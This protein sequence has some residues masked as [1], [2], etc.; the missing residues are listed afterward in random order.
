MALNLKTCNIRYI[1][2]LDIS[3]IWR[4]TGREAITYPMARRLV[5]SMMSCS[6]SSDRKNLRPL[7]HRHRQMT[8]QS[9]VRFPMDTRMWPSANR[10]IEFWTRNRGKKNIVKLICSDSAPI[11]KKT[12][13]WINHELI[14][15]KV[16][17]RAWNSWFSLP[18]IPSI[19]WK[20]PTKKNPLCDYAD[21]MEAICS[22]L[23][24]I[25]IINSELIYRSF[26]KQNAFLLISS[27]NSVEWRVWWT[28]GGDI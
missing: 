2:N 22:L 16:L 25:T 14:C 23:L 1:E 13:K 26:N 6:C 9:S 4:E 5:V 19:R 17:W 20:L 27:D 21:E 3:S 24:H 28:S 18:Q 11:F 12:T 10:Q 15:W 7:H 8:H